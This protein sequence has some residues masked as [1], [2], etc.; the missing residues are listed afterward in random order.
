MKWLPPN[1]SAVTLLA[2]CWSM[3]PCAERSPD[4]AFARFSVIIGSKGQ[5]R[6]IAATSA[7]LI[8]YNSSARCIS[9]STRSV[10]ASDR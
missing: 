2:I 9:R 10:I 8:P 7:S 1:A 6:A 4:R 3:I 5:P